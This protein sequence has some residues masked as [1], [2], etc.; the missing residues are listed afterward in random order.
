MEDEHV[1]V[2]ELP[3]DYY[4]DVQAEYERLNGEY[5]RQNAQTKQC[6]RAVSHAKR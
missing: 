6:S 1:K 4:G 3:L 5:I 2:G